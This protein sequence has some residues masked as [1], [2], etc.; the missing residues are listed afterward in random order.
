[1]KYNNENPFKE[2]NTN[3]LSNLLN[4]LN[5]KKTAKLWQQR[6]EDFMV[7]DYL[8]MIYP[9]RKFFKKNKE[10]YKII[11]EPCLIKKLKLLSI[12]NIDQLNELIKKDI[13]MDKYIYTSK[14]FNIINT[15]YLK[16]KFNDIEI[17]IENNITFI[18]KNAKI[19]AMYNS[20][21]SYL[22]YKNKDYLERLI[23]TL[24]ESFFLKLLRLNNE[25]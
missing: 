11:K 13:I 17:I 12:E 1:M 19:E 7:L 2:G 25:I 6:A 22:Y 10:N 18:I 8:S 3:E 24:S 9:F 5:D 14:K 4:S 16:I 20:N 21:D 15:R 23:E